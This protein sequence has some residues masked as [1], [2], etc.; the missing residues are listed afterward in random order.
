MFLVEVLHPA[1]L[2]MFL[3]E[4]LHP[5]P[6]PLVMFLVE[7]G[8]LRQMSKFAMIFFGIKIELII[9]EVPGCCSSPRGRST[10]SPCLWLDHGRSR[11][12]KYAYVIS[13]CS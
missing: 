3:V 1:P 9:K 2:V 5:P 12:T 13:K 6:P 10:R 11:E 7:V 4:V 8:G